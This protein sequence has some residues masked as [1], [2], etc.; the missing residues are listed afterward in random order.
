MTSPTLAAQLPP[1][2]FGFGRRVPLVMQSEAAE[3]GLACLAMIAGYHGYRTD[4]LS[5]RQRFAISLKGAT[6]K[7]LIDIAAALQ[8]SAR[9]LRLEL[10]DLDKLQAPC[11]LHWDLNHFVVLKQVLR[12]GSG[13]LIHDPARGEVRVPTTEVSTRFTGVALELT[14]TPR[15]EKKEEKQRIRLRE[16][17]GSVS[18][19]KR[20]LIQILLLALALEVF[21]LVSPFLMQWVVDGAIL[22][23]DRDLLT[24]LVLGFG[25]LMTIQTGIGLARSWVVMYMST[26][27]NLQWIANVFT[28][29]LRLPLSYFEKRHLGDVVSRFGAV[30]AI[31]RTLTTSFVEAILDGLMA[32]A[33]LGMMLIYSLTLSLV[34]FVSVALYALLRWAAYRPLRRAS[35]EQIVLAAREQSLFLESIRGVQSIKL[36]NHEEERRARWLNAVADATNRGIATQKMTLGFGT[37]HTFVAGA[38]NLLIVWLGAHLAMDN[39][40]SVG[41]LFAFVSYKTSFTGRVY[42]LIDKWVELKMLSLQAERLADIVLSEPEAVANTPATDDDD[43]SKTGENFALGGRAEREVT[44]ATLETRNLSFRYSDAEPWILRNLNLKILPGESVAVIGPSGCGKTTLVKLLLGLLKPTEGEVLVGGIP[45][46]R[47]G[48]RNY[49]A[50]LGAV[51]QEDQL[52]AG[53]IADNI[54]FFDLRMDREW[55]ESCARLAAIHEEI[56]VMPMGYQTLIGDMGTALSGGQK[57]RLL[58]ARALYK[59]PKLLFL[60]EATSHLDIFNEHRIVKALAE[61]KLT[62][63]VVAHRKETIDGAGRIIALAPQAGAYRIFAGTPGKEAAT[64]PV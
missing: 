19:L 26:H 54:G 22:S 18:G 8:L 23:A 40:F 37:A 5:L 3:C 58:L 1:L 2:H 48:V 51:M 45:L 38:E 13:I 64:A 21:A 43:R 17:L 6:L 20:S 57:Q 28:H 34:V 61:L 42:S 9:P 53:S 47:M 4:L 12:N 14:P 31:Q 55:L 63:I 24:L 62:R 11:I 30:G 49:R 15:F 10:E 60:D 52:L 16:M 33:T 36:F 29:L 44:D 39:V 25:L 27:L 50:M 46:E 59:R 32:V 7:S 56:E 41:M 35:E